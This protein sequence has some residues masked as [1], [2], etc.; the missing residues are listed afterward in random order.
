MTN[1]AQIADLLSDIRNWL[2]ASSYM[3]V[4]T[5]LEKA[6][7]DKQSRI[8]YQMLDGRTSLEQVRVKAKMSP[9]KLISLTQKWT[10][11][12]LMEAD[13]EK[14]KKRLFDLDD[15]ELLDPIEKVNDAKKN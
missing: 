12:G 9:N 13:N 2:R 7:P 11:M 4:K 8:A 14:R 3:A 6:L 10:S 1:D 15:F 5:L